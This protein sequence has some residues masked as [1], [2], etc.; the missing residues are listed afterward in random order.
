M[1]IYLLDTSAVRFISGE[2]LAEKAS[3][4]ALMASPFCFWEIASHLQD[5][6][7]FARIKA[8]LMKFRHL[9]VLNEPTASAEHD[10]A[11]AQ[12]DVDDSLEASGRHLCRPCSPSSIKLDRG[13]FQMSNP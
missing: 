7:D 11:L 13:V 9:K 4:V 10:L 1:P 12:I 2:R 6:G 5:E 3:D 8:N